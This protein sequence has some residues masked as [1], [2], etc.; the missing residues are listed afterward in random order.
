[1]SYI[2]SWS[3]QLWE[4]KTHELVLASIVTHTTEVGEGW[5]GWEGMRRRIRRLTIY[6]EVIF[7]WL[8]YMGLIYLHIRSRRT[9]VQMHAFS[10]IF[11]PESTFLAAPDYISVLFGYICMRFPRI[12]LCSSDIFACVLP[13]RRVYIIRPIGHSIPTVTHRHSWK[14]IH[15]STTTLSFGGFCHYMHYFPQYKNKTCL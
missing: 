4:D 15:N 1:M 5:G 6:F 13:R 12:F 9:C 8:G 2:S 10:F 7:S 14:L 3:I 11:H